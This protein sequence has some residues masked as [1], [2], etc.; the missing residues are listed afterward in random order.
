MCLELGDRLLVPQGEPDVVEPFEKPPPSVVVDVERHGE[1]TDAHRTL[2]QIDGDG[3]SRVGL[4]LFPEPLDVLV[5]DLR[6]EESL[7]AGVAAED[8]AEA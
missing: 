2:N 4:D 7:L 5:G 6:G 3:Y 1:R 8:V